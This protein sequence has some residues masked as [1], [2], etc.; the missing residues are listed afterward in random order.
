M[1]THP[2]LINLNVGG[3]LY[4][5]DFHRILLIQGRNGLGTTSDY[6]K[7]IDS[8]EQTALNVPMKMKVP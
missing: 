7:Q 4:I 1:P 5:A 6:Y 2:A 8:R 3:K